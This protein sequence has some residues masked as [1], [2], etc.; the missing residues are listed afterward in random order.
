MHRLPIFAFLTLT[1]MR[2]ECDELFDGASEQVRIYL[3]IN[4]HPD[5]KVDSGLLIIEHMFAIIYL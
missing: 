1:I 3:P 4:S 2:G 5:D